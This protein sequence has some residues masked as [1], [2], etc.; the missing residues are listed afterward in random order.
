MKVFF[1]TL[2]LLVLTTAACFAQTNITWVN[3]PGYRLICNPLLSTNNDVSNLFTNPPW[4]LTFCK[5]NSAGTGYDRTTYD[6]DVPG[7]TEPLTLAP[8]EGAFIYNPLA[9]N[10]TNTFYGEA[11][12][13]STNSI[14]PG[15]SIRSRISPAYLT[16]SANAQPITICFFTQT[17]SN[18]GY[19]CTTYDLDCGCWN[20]GEPNPG[21]GESYW[22]VNPA[23]NGAKS[24]I[25]CTTNSP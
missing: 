23:A 1:S 7:W 22:I 2:S 8:G 13:C 14:P 18:Y 12:F 11:F 20:N 6:P 19:R 24:W 16:N 5:R 15:F 4:G 3:P 10:Y 21:V 25:T 17:G 9:Q